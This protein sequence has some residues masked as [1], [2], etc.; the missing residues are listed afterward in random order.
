V[1]SRSSE[2]YRIVDGD[3]DIS[4]EWKACNKRVSYGLYNFSSPPSEMIDVIVVERGI[5]GMATA[6]FCFNIRQKVVVIE[7]GYI[8][9]GETS[10]TIAHIA[11]ALDNR[12][13]ELEQRLVTQR[14]TIIG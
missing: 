9:S 7:D 8:E 13:Y 4:K 11:H 3:E 1:L 2:M 6:Y 12:R 5:A 14:T 10:S